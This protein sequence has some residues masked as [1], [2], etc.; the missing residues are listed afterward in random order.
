MDELL[1]HCLRELSFDG[2]LGCNVSRLRDF[3]VDFYAHSGTPQNT[4]DA[5]CAFVWSLVAQ[6]PTVRIGT[7][8]PG[9]TSEVWI[10]PQISAK[11]KA[12]AK[13]EEHVETTPTQL[14][15]VPGARERSL[16]D[17]QK[18]YGDKLR[19]AV[20]PDAIYAAV[21]GSHIRFAKLS[22]MVYSAL[23]IVT[24]GRDN[25]VTVVELGQ[26]SKYDQKTCFY[27]VRQLTELDLV[28]GLFCSCATMF[29][30]QS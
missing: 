25:G 2:D 11:R 1:H 23:Q 20:D 5:F 7:V 16:D 13:G 4:D 3:I 24:R 27:L 12:K 14:D 6:Q 29:N 17:L 18:E 19:I 30:A 15:I 22:P 26:K 8:P 10:A 28:Y 21:T 9:V